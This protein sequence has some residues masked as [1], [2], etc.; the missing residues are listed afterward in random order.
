MTP[1][2]TYRE[3][4]ALAR[5]MQRNTA[6]LLTL[7]GLE[8][9]L[10]RLQATSYRDDFVLKGGVLLA[11]YK[12]RRPTRDLDMRAI[13]V[14]LDEERMRAVLAAIAVPRS[15]PASTPAGS[16]TAVASAA[17]GV[18][19]AAG[20]R[21][22]GLSVRLTLRAA[23]STV[24]ASRLSCRWWLLVTKP[25]AATTVPWASKTGAAIELAPIVISSDVVA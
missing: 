23:S 22:A 3:L 5:D 2:Q 4:Q 12:L 6:E 14:A 24:G 7:Y 21:R 20:Y 16:A 15:R 10:A 9:V 17:R 11:A 1:A 13:D 18:Q 19:R 8:R 25:S